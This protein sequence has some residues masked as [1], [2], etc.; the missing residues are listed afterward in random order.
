LPSGMLS[1]EG[2]ESLF[3][4]PDPDRDIGTSDRYPGGAEAHR[5]IGAPQLPRQLLHQRGGRH[6]WAG[7][8]DDAGL[9]HGSG[10]G[11]VDGDGA[12]GRV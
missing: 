12:Q 3:E 8:A 11:S 4:I 1:E 2:F 10:E 5:K 6:R 7:E 9:E